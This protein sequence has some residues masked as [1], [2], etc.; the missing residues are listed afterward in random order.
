MK[1]TY[2][3]CYTPL[4]EIVSA[5][6]K[7][8]R[9]ID[10][11]EHLHALFA[12][13]KMLGVLMVASGDGACSF[14]YAFSGNVGGLSRVEGFVPPI[15]DQNDPEGHFRKQEAV[16][17]GI[18]RRIAEL[19]GSDGEAAGHEI[20]ELQSRRK[21]LSNEL[22]EW[23]FE[24]YRVLNG[25]GEERS[26]REVFAE[27]GLIPP[28]GTGECAAP[29]LLDYAYRHQLKP[30]A[31]GEFWY[32]RSPLKEVRHQ[33]RFYPSCTG[34]CGPLL[35]YML[36]G[37]EVEE[38]PLDSDKIWLAAD[39]KPAL[40]RVLFED[41]HIIVV[42]K[43]SGMLSVPGRTG[44]K[45]SL[46][47]WLAAR[48]GFAGEVHSCHRLDMDTSGLMVFAKDLRTKADIEGQFAQ[49]EVH[50]TY[51]ARLCATPQAKQFR[52]GHKGVISIPLMLDYYDRP[53]QMADFEQGKKAVTQFEVIANLPG[54][55]MD[56]RF[57]P[58][59]G[60]TH[61]LRVHAAHPMGL[62]RPILGDRLYGGIEGSDG[63]QRLC[64]HADSL[65]FTHP[66]TGE[67]MEFHSCK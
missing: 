10:S 25:R 56:V 62:G 58:L 42:D 63:T 29:K 64:L 18:N 45:Q 3:F 4:S 50:K 67:E 61:Q 14:L 13:G 39:G 53:R 41:E 60:R 11:D 36:E 55:E 43:P 8:I 26:I 27:R 30:I 32:G 37:L 12:E 15:F 38:N 31:M 17:S 35:S 22:Q 28:S 47:E 33:G 46:Q 52:V 24:Q 57:T 19:S 48:E 7:L 66:V 5:A 59:T 49:R 44:S 23:L 6:E 9:K 54:G 16:I 51:Q 1:F 34:K 40:P 20:A 21:A 2:P 65:S